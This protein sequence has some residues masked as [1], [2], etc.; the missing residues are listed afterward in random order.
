MYAKP[1]LLSLDVATADALCCEVRVN[2]VIVR[3]PACD[4]F[5][6]DLFDPCS[7]TIGTDPVTASMG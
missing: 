1:S 3:T 7:V 6:C 4:T 2:N 5:V